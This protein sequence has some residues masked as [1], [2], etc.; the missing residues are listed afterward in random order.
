MTGT[1]RLAY[2]IMVHQSAQYVRE[3]FELLFSPDAWFFYH[4]DLKAPQGLKAFLGHLTLRYGNVRV[5]PPTYCSWGGFSLT[6]AMVNLIRAALAGSDWDQLIFLSETHL[7]LQGYPAICAALTHDHNYLDLRRVQSLPP[8]GRTDVR[9]RFSQTYVEL[10]GVGSFATAS[11]QLSED[12]FDSLYHASQWMTL[13]RAT[14]ERIPPL[15]SEY[16]Q[17]FRRAV[18]SDENA[19]QTWIGQTSSDQTV[20][21][22]LTFVAN[23]ANGGSRDMTFDDQIFLKARDLHYLFIRKRPGVLGGL[24]AEWY[25]ARR[26]VKE[27]ITEIQGD[28]SPETDSITVALVVQYLNAISAQDIDLAPMPSKVIGPSM[29]CEVRNPHLRHPFTVY[30]LSQDLRRYKVIAVLHQDFSSFEESTI[31]SYRTSVIRMRAHNLSFH[32]EI[33][34][35]SDCNSGYYDV[36]DMPDFHGLAGVIDVFVRR[37]SE[38]TVGP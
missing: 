33:H 35:G 25:A 11:C 27:D 17:P 29:F 34:L 20:H 4:V 14:C 2:A 22:S 16:F 38:L 19:L 36:N 15:D 24:A 28:P 13:C 7:P 32:R 9:S 26:T 31:C 6:S 8:D 30:V 1:P 10:P 18:L 21:R 23:P 5:I 37:T 3:Q 12:F